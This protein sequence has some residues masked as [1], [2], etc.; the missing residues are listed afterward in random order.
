M[1]Y[2]KCGWVFVKHVIFFVIPPAAVT[3]ADNVASSVMAEPAMPK[4]VT[5]AIVVKNY[6]AAI[7]YV[8]GAI[9]AIAVA[10]YKIKKRK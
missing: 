3:V 1:Q 9:C 5:D 8:V 2:L 10:R 7:G 4:A 6:T